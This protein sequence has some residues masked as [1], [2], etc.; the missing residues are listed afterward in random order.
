MPLDDYTFKLSDSGVVLNTDLTSFPFVDIDKVVGLDSA[1]YRETTRDHEGTDGGFID[2]EFERGR[3]IFLEGTVYCTVGSE[4]TYMD[5]LK[6]NFAPVTTPIPF[7]F[8]APGVNERVIF[9]KSRGTTYDWDQ[10]RRIGATRI[11]FKLYAE[12]PRIYNN[13]LLSVVIPFGGSATTGIGFNLSFNMDFGAAIPPNGSFIFNGGNRS[14]PATMTIT[15]PAVDPRI[16]ND[17]LSKSLNF[18]ITLG[19]SDSLVVDLANRTVTLNGS[20]NVR[21]ALTTSDWFLFSPGNTFIRFGGTSGSGT[22]T[23]SYRYAWR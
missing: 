9:V 6:Q 14:T 18:T 16:I 13:S 15:G 11:Q 5:S 20:T 21:N 22:L 17:T 2:A 1:P 8:K 4:E 10:L 7:Y 3:D 19:V 23:V 12:D